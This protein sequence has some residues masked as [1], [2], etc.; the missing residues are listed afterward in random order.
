MKL[1]HS[2][3]TIKQDKKFYNLIWCTVL[4]CIYAK[5][6][7]FTIKLYTDSIAYEYLKFAPYD[8]I[9]VCLDELPNVPSIYANA[10]MEALKRE[11]IGSIHIDCDV[12]LKHPNLV[13]EL[14]T[15]KDL[16]IQSIEN[17]GDEVKP[18]F[19]LGYLWDK[20][21][22]NVK[23]LFVPAY[24]STDCEAMYNCGILGFNNQEL[25]DLFISEYEKGFD[26]IKNNIDKIDPKG[27]CD[28]ILEQQHLYDICKTYNYSVEFLLNNKTMQEDAVIK[29]YQHLLGGTKHIYENTIK[30]K[31]LVYNK[32]FEVYNNLERLINKNGL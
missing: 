28:L 11:P 14:D 17:Y 18:G 2:F 22:K 29:G 1:I 19:K 10:K 16:I 12:F 20:A 9:E 27:V 7:G 3:K 25:K 15:D 31:K 8:E 6:S 26:I 5:E 13:K 24:T 30:V 32:N 21:I 4:S 23:S